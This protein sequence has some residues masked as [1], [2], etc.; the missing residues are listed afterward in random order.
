MV[1]ATFA[2]LIRRIQS[3]T[4]DHNKTPA[5]A[6]ELEFYKEI[7]KILGETFEPKFIDTLVS[8]NLRE[9]SFSK[10]SSLARSLGLHIV[11]GGSGTVYLGWSKGLEVYE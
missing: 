10:A 7:Y 4:L 3:L 2:D 1:N 8:I 11:Q 9:L 5:E 6:Q